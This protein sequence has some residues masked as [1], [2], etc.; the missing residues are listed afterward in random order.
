[1]ELDYKLFVLPLMGLAY[2]KRMWLVDKCFTVYAKG[3]LMWEQYFPQSTA[4]ELLNL[5]YYDCDH[6]INPIDLTNQFGHQLERSGSVSWDDIF[7]QIGSKHSEARLQLRYKVGD[8]Q[9][10]CTFSYVDQES[11]PIKFPLY[12]EDEL[13]NHINSGVFRNKVLNASVGDEDVT[14]VVKEH[15]GPLDDFHCTVGSSV[16]KVWISKNNGPLELVDSMAD[17]YTYD[18]HQHVITINKSE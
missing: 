13:E 8:Q 2:Y 12:S 6:T 17:V 9:Y 1:M 3:K 10:R 5:Y 15:H 11:K 14:D 7:E 4:H 16:K 18:D